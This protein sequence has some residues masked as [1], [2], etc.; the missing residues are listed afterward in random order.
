ME[1]YTIYKT[2]L[3]NMNISTDQLVAPEKIESK[4]IFMRNY[5]GN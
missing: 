4:T 3:E 5:N 1:D 2:E